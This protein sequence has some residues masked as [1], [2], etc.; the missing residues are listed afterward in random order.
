VDGRLL[1]DHFAL[2]QL[3]HLP[4]AE[5][6]AFL[7]GIAGTEA[8]DGVP[9][10]PVEP[11]SEVWAAGV[12]Y[13]RSREAREAES[14]VKDVY[15]KVY[16]AERPEL[17][18]K[19][20][21]WRVAGHGMPI[22]IRR[23]SRW[24]VPEPELTLV[25]NA[26]GEIAGFCAGNDVSSRDIEGAN[27][28]YLPQAKMYDGSCALGP[29]IALCGRE[30]LADLTIDLAVRR[31]GRSIFTGS[32]RTSQIRRPLQDLVDYLRRELDFPHGVFL[33][34][35]TGIVP[36]DDF[37]LEHGDVVRIT[38]GELTLENQVGA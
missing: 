35:G 32:T 27:P 23:D 14:A 21:G 18:F 16:D 19:A 25:V 9:L 10:A 34:T 33:M 8:A 2:H 5:M 15:A 20:P 24:N 29:G 37:S 12:T 22:R 6:T 36:P 11:A 1:P 7:R 4:V 30:A 28:L 38:I 31:A 3:L 26:R 13:L 17:F